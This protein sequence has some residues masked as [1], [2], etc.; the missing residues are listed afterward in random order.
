MKATIFA[1]ACSSRNRD[2][3]SLRGHS[4]T[5][6]Q[7]SALFSE[8]RRTLATPGCLALSWF[9]R[10]HPDH[11]QAEHGADHRPAHRDNRHVHESANDREQSPGDAAEHESPM[12]DEMLFERIH[13]APP[14]R[15]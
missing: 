3:P 1:R 14:W 6:A 10:H 7:A 9:E 5:L 13:D 11:L 8:A 2:V 12:M 4:G 15:T